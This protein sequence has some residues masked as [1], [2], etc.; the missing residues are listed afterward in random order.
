M[1]PEQVAS[2]TR[3]IT[4]DS[5][6]VNQAGRRYFLFFGQEQLVATNVLGTELIGW[7]AEVLG[8]LPN[9]VQVQPNRG[10]RIMTELE[11]LQHPLSK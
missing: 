3:A 1:S 8:K 2:G 10:R 6:A 11:I 7:L 5:A 4:G 9:G